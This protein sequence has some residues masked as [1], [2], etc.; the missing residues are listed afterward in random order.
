MNTLTLDTEPNKLLTIKL[1]NRLMRSKK[2]GPNFNRYIKVCYERIFIW[3][4]EGKLRTQTVE[5]FRCW[6]EKFHSKLICDLRGR[7]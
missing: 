6:C 5:N 7:Y 4:W 1:M 2:R 3:R